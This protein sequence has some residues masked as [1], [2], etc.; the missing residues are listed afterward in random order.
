[1]VRAGR[2]EVPRRNSRFRRSARDSRRSVRL[3]GR[4]RGGTGV[5]RARRRVLVAGAR[6][7]LDVT[8]TLWIARDEG[9]VDP[10]TRL[11][12]LTLLRRAELIGQRAGFARVVVEG[13]R[14]T[15]GIGPGRLVVL[16]S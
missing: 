4:D 15:T 16:S 8:A 10:E 14:G 5:E 12:G 3:P 7:S 1:M 9:G 6:G 13:A 2:G 11:L